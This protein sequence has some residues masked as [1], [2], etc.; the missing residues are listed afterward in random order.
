MGVSPALVRCGDA[1]IKAA[2]SFQRFTSRFPAF[3]GRSDSIIGEDICI[4]VA[5][6]ETLA[7]QSGFEAS[8]YSLHT[9]TT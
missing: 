1:I 5:Y 7:Q 2:T 6:W 9:N 4:G 8:T 3:H